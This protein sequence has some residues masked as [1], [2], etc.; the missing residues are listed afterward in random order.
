MAS[1]HP[2]SE[3]SSSEKGPVASTETMMPDEGSPKSPTLSQH[4]TSTHIEGA[5]TDLLLGAFLPCIPVA[6]VCA[7]LLTIIFYYRVDLDPGWELLQVP[8]SFNVNNQTVLNELT[9]LKSKGG[10]SAYFVRFNPGLLVAIASWTAKIM[11]FLTGSSM[12]LVAFFAGRRVL[13]AT[14]SNTP[15]QL[16]SP[17]QTALL[18]GLLNESGVKPL[19]NVIKYRW[20]NHERIVQ[21]IPIA[22]AALAFVVFDIFAIGAAETWFGAATKPVNRAIISRHD[23]PV[24]SHGRG[25]DSSLCGSNIWQPY[26]C[27]S[28]ATARCQ[29]PCSITS[30]NFT[31]GG[32]VTQTKQA[33]AHAQEA[34]ET[35]LGNSWANKIQN[36]SINAP[37]D[38]Y[39]DRDDTKFYFLGDTT[40][41]KDIIDFLANTTSVTTSCKVVTQQCTIDAQNEGFSCPWGFNSP[42]FTFSGAVGVDPAST[43]ASANDSAV[44]IQFFKDANLTKAIGYGSQS[45]ELFSAQNPVHFMLWSKGFPPIDTRTS[46]FDTMTSGGY[47]KTDYSGDNVF[48]LNCSTTIYSTVY[49]WVN[50]N[51]LSADHKQ[52]WYPVRAPDTYGAIY[53]APFAIN[54]ALGRLALSDAAAVAAYGT[55]PDKV[56]DTFANA[57][58]RA[59]V[60][61]TAGINTPVLNRL[62][63]SRNDTVILTRVP[64]IPLY[65][66]VSLKALYAL[67]SLILAALVVFFARPAE[68]QEVKARLTVDGLA[69]GFFEPKKRQERAVDK[70]EKLYGEHDRA[71]RRDEEGGAEGAT[72]KV[73]IRQTQS[74][75]WVWVI[76]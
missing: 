37:A 70:I 31:T 56:A 26:P 42:S 65:F 17:H 30:Y 74:G 39:G 29:Y 25:L 24:A 47:L 63:Q 49:A 33:I 10:T 4:G 15:E 64:K 27:P 46:T 60:A 52:G 22:F 43:A 18:I 12:A 2:P 58:S 61:L 69:A 68:A 51:I 9:Q 7:V 28:N 44:G 66:L 19:W 14:K 55:T 59:A 71:A 50:G 23:R 62:E 34:A 8:S 3:P 76:Q 41:G 6:L 75:G 67:F 13:D 73:G 72:K 36:T 11:P 53:S 5:M 20:Q 32:N 38:D 35:L 48:M 54:S 16:P 1:P 21:P 57:F 40:A 45:V